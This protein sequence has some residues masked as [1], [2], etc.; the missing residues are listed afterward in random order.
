LL[1][2]DKTFDEIRQK[3]FLKFYKFLLM[4]PLMKT[5]LKIQV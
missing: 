1:V 3:L 2:P 5:F 4:F